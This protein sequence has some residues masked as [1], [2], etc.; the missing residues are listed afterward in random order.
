MMTRVRVGAQKLGSTYPQAK[1][2][3][4]LLGR[5]RFEPRVCAWAILYHY[6]YGRGQRC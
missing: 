4:F 2:I 3:Q 6:R 1:G 5:Q